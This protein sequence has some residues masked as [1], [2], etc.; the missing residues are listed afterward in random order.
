MSYEKIIYQSGNIYKSEFEAKKVNKNLCVYNK[1]KAVK[2]RIYE[3]AHIASQVTVTNGKTFTKEAQA[4]AYAEKLS[5]LMDF[6]FQEQSE[7][8]EKNN[9]DHA[10]H[11]VQVAYDYAISL[12]KETA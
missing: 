12:E 7:F 10:V 9:P 6:D 3:V 11:N 1:G 5:D 2:K 4:I 8:W